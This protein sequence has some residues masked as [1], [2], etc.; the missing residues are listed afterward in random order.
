[1]VRGPL[2]QCT[3]GL[4]VLAQLLHF[5]AGLRVLHAHLLHHGPQFTYLILQF[6]NT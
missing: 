2:Q 3:G 1:M 6:A 4:Q 5:G